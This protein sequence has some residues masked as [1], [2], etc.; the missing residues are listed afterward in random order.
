MVAVVA[1]H[2]LAKAVETEQCA[3]GE[4]RRR[5]LRVDAA[6]ARAVQDGCRMLDAELAHVASRVAGDVPDGVDRELIPPSPG[7]R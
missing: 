5:F 2:V 1:R 7:P 6:D 4:R 3:L